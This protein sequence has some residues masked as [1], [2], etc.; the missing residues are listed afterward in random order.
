LRQQKQVGQLFK[1]RADFQSALS[2][3]ADPREAG[4][5]PAGR[6]KSCPTILENHCELLLWSLVSLDLV[7]HVAEWLPFGEA[8]HI[9]EYQLVIARAHAIRHRRDMRRDDD[10]LE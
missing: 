9:V 10:V 6:M 5:K 2:R 7:D 3:R 1:L 4:W 8:R